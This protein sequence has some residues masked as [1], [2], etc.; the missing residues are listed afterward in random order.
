MEDESLTPNKSRMIFADI[1]RG[2][3]VCEFENK[4]F[5]I[6]HLTHYDSTDLDY[7]KEKHMRL[8]KKAGLHN[9]KE[10]M[11]DLEKSKLWLP[12]DDQKIKDN[13]SFLINLKV[14]K[15]KLFLKDERERL[16]EQIKG[17]EKETLDLEIKKRTLLGVTCE[18]FADK[19]INELYIYNSAFKANNL[20][21][22]FFSKEDFDELE[23]TELSRFITIYNDK[24][25][26]F[27]SL[28]LKRVALSG[29]FLNTFYL[30]KDN[31]FIFYGKPLVNLTY[32]QI[33]LFTQGRYFKSILS[34]STGKP[35]EDMMND[36]DKIIE[37]YES[38]KNAQT[39]MDKVNKGKSG[40]SSIVGASAKDMKRLGAIGDDERVIDLHAEA[41][42]KGGSLSMEDMMKL[43]GH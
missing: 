29:I 36:P 1:L 35:P 43:H 40:G 11:E 31:P 4:S 28:N 15:S 42:K 20:N 25:S 7:E 12:N 3:S 38:S 14:T 2:Y 32:Y 30:C 18:S 16:Q 10:Q 13:Q 41:R 23:S 33:E 8:A 26:D 9:E 39:T 27:Q 24:L 19:K 17:I 5:Y 37:W 22:H 21:E 6:K 34:D